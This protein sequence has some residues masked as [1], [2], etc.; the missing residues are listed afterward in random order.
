MSTKLQG[1]WIMAVSLIFRGIAL[2]VVASQAEEE[3][4]R[5]LPGMATSVDTTSGLLGKLSHNEPIN[6]YSSYIER[7]K[8]RRI[9]SQTSGGR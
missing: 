1:G 6:Q 8:H 9:L 3:W 2:A 4:R 5:T 7:G